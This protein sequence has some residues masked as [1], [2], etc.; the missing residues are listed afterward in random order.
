MLYF[1]F[2][3]DLFAQQVVAPSLLNHSTWRVTPGTLALLASITA[4]GGAIGAFVSSGLSST[5][6]RRASIA[7]SVGWISGC[8]LFAGVT[9]SFVAFGVSRFLLGIGLGVLAPLI[10]VLVVDWSRPERRSLY[11]CVAQSGIPLG[12]LAAAGADHT[13]LAG[14]NF[15]WMFLLGALPILLGPVYWTLIPVEE[16]LEASVPDR[17]TRQ[18]A[19]VVTSEW[20]GLF[21]RGWLLAS[22]LFSIASFIGLLMIYGVGYW[23]P[24]LIADLSSTFEFV[25]AFNSGAVAVTLLFAAIADRVPSK[26]CIVTL[27]MCAMVAMYVLPSLE[28]RLAI[29]GMVALAGG[30]IL[31]AQNVLCAYVARYYPRPMRSTALSFTLG[32][33]RFGSFIGPSYVILLLGVSSDPK[34]DF[35]D[36]VT[37]VVIGIAAI[38]MVPAPTSRQSAKKAQCES[39]WR[40]TST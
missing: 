4:L 27:F 23:L 30:G 7:I 18:D 24:T 13:L 40:P 6:R 9:S 10:C 25:I 28:S 20:W 17:A 36:L 2:G 32:V 11:C 34:S 15:Q 26:L 39:S 14:T 5:R 1:V 8:M 37:P 12:A 19:R 33:G 38:L 22:T 35:Y 31:G 29:L 21:E 3:Y 16:P